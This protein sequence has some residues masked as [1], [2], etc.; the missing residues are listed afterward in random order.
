MRAA[1]AGICV[2]LREGEEV[3]I[4]QTKLLGPTLVRRVGSPDAYWTNGEKIQ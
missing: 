3:V 4:E 1:G 2:I